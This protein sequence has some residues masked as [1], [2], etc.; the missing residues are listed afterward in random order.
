MR[1][2]W[3]VL[4]V[5]V[6]GIIAL[7]SRAAVS[8]P[9][10]AA[11]TP[12]TAVTVRQPTS[13]RVPQTLSLTGT[14]SARDEL[15]VGSEVSGLRLEQVLVDEGDRVQRGQVLAVLDAS[16]LRAQLR[17]ARARLA[18]SQAT[19]HKA[20]QPNR[21]QDVAGLEHGVAQAGDMLAQARDTLDQ[22]RIT[23]RTAELNRQR[24]TELLRQAYVTR[25]EFENRSMEA[26]RDESAVRAAEHQVLAARAT[27]Q[28]A[29]DRLSLAKAGG[30]QEDVELAGASTEEAAGAVQQLQAQIDQTIIR[31]PD[32]GLIERRDAHLGDITSPGKTL[33]LLARKS[34]LELRAEV[35]ESDLTRIRLGQEVEVASASRRSRGRV[36]LITP[37]IDATTR[38]GTARVALPGNVGLMPGMF[39]HAQLQLGTLDALVVPA[40]AVQGSA[41]QPFVYLLDGSQARRHPVVLGQRF[42]DDV[43]VLSGLTAHDA[44]IVAGAAFLTDGDTVHPSAP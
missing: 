5:L 2:L 29:Q 35:P 37:S 21:P 12:S 31:A 40:D 36:W 17:Q 1:K 32:D 8:V 6:A 19:L 23:A 28:Q 24:Y 13:R 7:R 4:V 34:L 33:F 43:Q 27:A 39:V 9:A 11:S 26:D 38:L 44:V 18:E 20:Y 3:L 22:A 14:V 41:E 15:S 25:Q 16:V 30:R 42:S 10:P